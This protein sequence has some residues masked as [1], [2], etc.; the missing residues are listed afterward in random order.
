LGRYLLTRLLGGLVTMFL[1]SV[2]VFVLLALAPGDPAEL[3][4]MG[5]QT[6]PE[7]VAQLRHELGLDMPLY[8]QY[9]Q[10]A[11]DALR[12][13]L[14][15]SW[16]N[17]EP[18]LRELGR[19]F[20]AT[21]SLSLWALFTST[22]IGITVGVIAAVRQYS[23]L[24]FVTRSLV[25]IGVSMPIFWLGLILISLF[26]VQ[27]HWLPSSGRGSWKHLV[28]P[29]ISLATYSVGIIARMARSS[30]LEVLRD[31]YIRTAR[32]K[33]LPERIVHLR[34]ALK[35]AL[36]PIVTVVGLQLGY[37]LGGAI[38]TETVFAYPGLGWRMMQA[39]F[40]RDYP[41]VRGGVLLMAASFIVVNL[42]VDILYV[43]LD[44]RIRYG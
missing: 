31:D 36:I 30:M 42:A 18:V 1:V 40:A 8:S 37:L 33:G 16:Q 2:I 27:L 13:D 32:A 38:L 7:A 14:G 39:L 9:I 44:P 10:F 24:D 29:V 6:T 34:H 25:L 19:V 17:N 23:V 21:V 26:A 15:R 20:P 12:G 5:Q 4:L 41:I 28:L 3:I 11:W 35:N 43:Y 22:V